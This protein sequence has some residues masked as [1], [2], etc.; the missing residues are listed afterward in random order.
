MLSQIEFPSVKINCSS[1]NKLYAKIC[2]VNVKIY[3]NY[4]GYADNCFPFKND[5]FNN[6]R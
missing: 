5:K 1:I 3:P 2:L 6:I 4:I